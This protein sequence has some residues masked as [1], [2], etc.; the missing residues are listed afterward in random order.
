MSH[1]EFLL[2]SVIVVLL[3]IFSKIYDL[4]GIAEDAKSELMQIEVNSAQAARHLSQIETDTTEIVRHLQDM[5]AEQQKLRLLTEHGN[6]SLE[7]V[8]LMMGGMLDAAKGAGATRDLAVNLGL[9]SGL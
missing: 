2:I 7:F 3:V 9:H 5:A 1:T 4:C 6:M 8:T